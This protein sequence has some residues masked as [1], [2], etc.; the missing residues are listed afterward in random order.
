MET[1]TT[2]LRTIRYLSRVRMEVFPERDGNYFNRFSQDVNEVF[3]VRMKVFPER[4][5]N[6]F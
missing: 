2:L 3:H 4:D 6:V 1:I 5:G